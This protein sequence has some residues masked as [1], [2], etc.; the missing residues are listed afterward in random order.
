MLPIRVRLDEPGNLCD[1]DAVE[2]DVRQFLRT[3][4]EGFIDRFRPEDEFG[5]EDLISELIMAATSA[6]VLS[7]SRYFFCSVLPWF[8]SSLFQFIQVDDNTSEL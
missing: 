4:G 7:F 5:K 3:I 1:A 8:W 6:A 2:P